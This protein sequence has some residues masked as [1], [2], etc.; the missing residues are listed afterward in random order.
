MIGEFFFSFENLAADFVEQL[1]NRG[2][3][4]SRGG[5]S[6]HDGA[7]DRQDDF[8]DMPIFFYAQ[9]YLHVPESHPV[10]FQS[11]ETRLDVSPQRRGHF[12]VTPRNHQ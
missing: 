1:I 3:H 9:D 2:V 12:N 11:F 10:S 7:V 5:L 6:L 8:G 4:F